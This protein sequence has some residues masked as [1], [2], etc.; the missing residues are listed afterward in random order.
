[1]KWIPKIGLLLGIGVLVGCCAIASAQ[2]DIQL[3]KA[4]FLLTGEEDDFKVKKVT[5]DEVT[6]QVKD[7]TDDTIYFWSD[8]VCSQEYLKEFEDDET[9]IMHRW[10]RLYSTKRLTVQV[11]K[12]SL[13]DL[14]ENDCLVHS[15][16]EVKS[17]RWFVEVKTADGTT[18][19][20]ESS[21]KPDLDKKQP[22][23]ICQFHLTVK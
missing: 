8:I 13:E 16:E 14:L 4:G 23:E 21:E 9:V 5:T 12:F 18:L 10:V 3:V 11:N 2:D 19:C 1:M 20:M 17:A 6:V 15:Q 7:L 22:A